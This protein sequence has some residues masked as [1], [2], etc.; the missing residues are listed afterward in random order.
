[1]TI[2]HNLTA[3]FRRCG[4]LVHVTFPRQVKTI[5][6]TY[7][8]GKMNEVIPVGYR[9][10]YRTEFNVNRNNN[11]NVQAPLLYSFLPSG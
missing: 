10:V 1:V 8:D 11:L 3:E 5:S 6:N 9:P 4:N 2:N 7:E